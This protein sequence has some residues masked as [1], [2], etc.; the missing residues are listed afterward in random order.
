[1]FNM[2]NYYKGQ[3]QTSKD[4]KNILL[5]NL[6]ERKVAILACT[7]PLRQLFRT[8]YNNGDMSVYAKMQQSKTKAPAYLF[9]A[10]YYI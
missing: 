7:H 6:A 5:T 10:F 9:L 2:R 3:E 1:M 4:Q 8:K